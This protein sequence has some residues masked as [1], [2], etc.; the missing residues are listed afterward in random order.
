MTTLFAGLAWQ[1][2]QRFGI[3][4]H[5][6][7]IDTTSLSVSGEYASKEEGD[8]VPLAITYGYSRDHRQDLKQ[9]MLALATTHDEDVPVFLRPLDGN[10]SDKV[11]LSATVK[12]VMKQLRE[13]LPEGQEQQIAVFDSGGYSETNVKSYNQ[14]NMLWITRVP[15]TSTAAKTAL[16]EEYEQWQPL[17][18]GSGD[19]VVRSMDLSQGKERWITSCDLT[20]ACMPQRSRWTKR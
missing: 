3:K 13:E 4:A 2:R 17:A 14:V 12:E 7:H 19:Y 1:A 8:P 11:S 16:E 20:H 10:S 9:W 5:Y 18:D 15:E 6:L